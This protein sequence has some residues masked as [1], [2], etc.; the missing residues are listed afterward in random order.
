MAQPGSQ[1]RLEPKSDKWKCALSSAIQRQSFCRRRKLDGGP[2]KLC[3]F[4]SNGPAMKRAVTVTCPTATSGLV[5]ST[6]PW[7]VPEPEPQESC[8][9]SLVT[10]QTPSNAKPV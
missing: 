3:Y 10:S 7:V 2:A 8:P 6:H 9:V 5:K 1:V 4:T